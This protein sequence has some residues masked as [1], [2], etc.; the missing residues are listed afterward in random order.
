MLNVTLM[1]TGCPRIGIHET[2][3]QLLHLLYKRFFLD[4]VIV[5]DQE[6]PEVSLGSVQIKTIMLNHMS[7]YKT[8]LYNVL[9]LACLIHMPSEKASLAIY[10]FEPCNFML[11]KRKWVKYK[12]LFINRI[13]QE[14]MRIDQSSTG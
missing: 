9:I 1:N 11:R 12:E 7:N 14:F 6:R 2:A 10:T 8:S 13:Q 5:T 3:V 4:D